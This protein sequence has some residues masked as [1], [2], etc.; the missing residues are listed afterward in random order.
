MP[1]TKLTYA[2][3]VPGGAQLC[4]RI[5]TRLGCQGRP[6]R[7]VV[8][9]YPYA[10]LALT[11]R[12]RE[13]SVQVRFSDL[14]QAAPRPVLEAAAGMLLAR[15]YGCPA[16]AA[17]T[18]RYRAYARL[19]STRRR[20][21]RVRRSRLRRRGRGSRGRVFNLAEV[22][23]RLNRRYFA[24]RLL[25]PSLGWSARPWRRQFGCYDPAVQEILINC[26][27][28]RAA[29]PGLALD[30]VLFHEM[31]HVKHP[32]RRAGCTLVSHSA[33]F[34]GEEKGFQGYD[35]ARRILKRLV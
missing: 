3:A 35:E 33:R 2:H 27:L 13:D 26:R 34:R 7:F 32:T 6:P 31:L 9:F 30:Y 11:A 17:L 28:D 24:G 5:F 16:P 25:Q 12:K 10:N 1:K 14:L 23:R 19:A 21:L 4:R 20:I 29:V 18:A 8:E 15:F 22:F